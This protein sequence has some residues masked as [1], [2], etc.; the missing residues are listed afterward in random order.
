MS[1]SEK[2]ALI[3]STIS[4]R[5]S[6]YLIVEIFRIVRSEHMAAEGDPVA[7]TSA[8]W[9]VDSVPVSLPPN[10]NMKGRE[11]CEMLQKV[12]RPFKFRS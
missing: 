6:C 4:F 5:D 12:Y 3:E 1:S 9:I 2:Y 11:E 10:K 8:N 7:E